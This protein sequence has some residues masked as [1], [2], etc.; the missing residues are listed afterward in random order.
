[1]DWMGWLDGA[2]GRALAGPLRWRITYQNDGL[3]EVDAAGG[4]RVEL[5]ARASLALLVGSVVAY[6]AVLAVAYAL[7]ERLQGLLA[8]RDAHNLAL[9]MFSFAVFA[10]TT[11]MMLVEDHFA[12]FR[13][14][15]CKPIANPNFQLV[16]F[17][18]LVSK[19]WEWFDT[20][21]LI[22]KGNSLRFLHCLHHATT[23]W[24]YAVDHLFLSSIKYGVAVNAWIH[25]I[26]YRYVAFFFRRV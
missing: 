10:Y 25:F 12:S 17:L 5:S 6:G 15:T 18:F 20:V 1:M 14:A 21:L 4:P 24:L 16:S 3:F 23:F 19:I 8:L 13:D 26:M 7:K 22:L 2:V 9:A 11:W